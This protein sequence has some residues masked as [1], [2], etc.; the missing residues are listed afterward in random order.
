MSHPHND[1]LPDFQYFANL[2][3]RD[4]QTFLLEEYIQRWLIQSAPRKPRINWEAN[5]SMLSTKGKFVINCSLISPVSW[6]GHRF[7]TSNYLRT[8]LSISDTS[9][10]PRA[11]GLSRL[12]SLNR[13]TWMILLVISLSA[14]GDFGRPS[15]KN[16]SKLPVVQVGYRNPP[17]EHVLYIP[18][19]TIL[20]IRLVVKGTLFEE[21]QMTV[22]NVTVRKAFFV[23]KDLA[24]FDGHSWTRASDLLSSLVSVTLDSEGGKVELRLDQRE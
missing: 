3:P 4:M 2:R 9:R 15:V 20:P 17:D 10:P 11:S 5:L 16:I 19:S 1:L 18:G 23:H 13:L 8:G 24:S 6:K 12:R 7:A 22:T 14:C 21:D